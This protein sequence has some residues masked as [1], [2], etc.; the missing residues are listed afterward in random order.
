[1]KRI[2]ILL[3]LSTASVATAQPAVA[4]DAAARQLA[5][6]HF[7]RGIEFFNEERFDAALAELARAHELAP[8]HQTLY[9]L[10]RV[11]AALGHAVEAARAY[12]RYLREAGDAIPPRRRAEAEEA[13]EAQTVRIGHLDVETDIDGA[14][15]A[16]DGV[17]VATTPLPDPI[18]LSAGTHLVEVHAPGRESARRAVA[19]AGLSTAHLAVELR[20]AVVPRGS[21]QVT[22]SIPETTILV[23]GEEAGLSPLSST[24][25]LRAGPHV[26]EARR[27]GYRRETRTVDIE[28]GAEAELQFD[29][30]REPAASPDHLGRLRIALPDAPFLV[31]IDGEQMLGVDLELPVGAHHVTIE[32]TDR[33]PYEGTIRIRTGSAIDVSPPLTWTLEARR[34][35]LESAAGQRTLGVALTASGGGVALAGLALLVWNETEISRT[36]ARLRFINEQLGGVCRDMGFDPTCEAFEREGAT[37]SQEQGTQNVLRGVSIAGTLLGSVLAGTGLVLWLS[38]PSDE[39]IDA[40]ARARLTVRPNG[41][42]LDG[43]F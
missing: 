31:R 11:H 5:G 21:L 10:A 38:A 13:L 26:I 6:Q 43:A 9:N 41:L 24:L 1:M 36:D 42:T 32:V 17:D 27:Q 33:R 18:P 3:C 14:T 19:I 29:M 25:P 23:D 4:P 39:S 22:S 15:I 34:A 16:V 30:R 35:Q 20:E 37:L 2:L 8:A 28:E 7:D 40:D 12:A